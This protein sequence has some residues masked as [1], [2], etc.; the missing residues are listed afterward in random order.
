[1]RENNQR[2][3][4]VR[5]E[6]SREK[7]LYIEGEPRF[8]MKFLRQAVAD[9]KNLQ[10]VTLQRTADRKFLRL[11]IDR[12]DDLAGGFPKTREEL[13]AF[14]GLVLGSIEASAFTQDQLRMIADFVS[15]RGGGVL[16]LGGRRTFAEGGFAGTPIAEMLPVLIDG[17]KAGESFVAQVHATPT[18]A[19]ADARGRADRPDRAGLGRSLEIAPAAHDGEPADASEAR[20]GGAARWWAG[21]A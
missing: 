19:R 2:D 4:L 13:Y 12:P 18:R 3:A 21:R 5:V 1:M 8:E 10:I 14:Q 9:D 7:L 11:D 15:V 17:P 20:R 16:A 6:D